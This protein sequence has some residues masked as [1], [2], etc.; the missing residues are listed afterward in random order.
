MCLCVL[1]IQLL[2]WLN[3]FI[4]YKT[5]PPAKTDTD[6]SQWVQTVFH[7]IWHEYVALMV[8]QSTDILY[9]NHLETTIHYQIPISYDRDCVPFRMTEIGQDTMS[10]LTRKHV[11][12]LRNKNGNVCLIEKSA[13]YNLYI[14]HITNIVFSCLNQSYKTIWNHNGTTK[15]TLY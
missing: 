2:W 11:V 1:A 15:I 10:S 12:N 7:G 13:S 4:C 14:Q 6:N 5:P 8:R 3:S 9:S